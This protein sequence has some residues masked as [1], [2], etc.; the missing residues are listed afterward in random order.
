[1]STTVL[2]ETLEGV[3]TITL[4]RPDSLNAMNAELLAATAQAFEAA[5][6]DPAT[7]V[8]VLTGA[9]RAFCAGDDLRSHRQ[10]ESEAEAFGMVERIQRVT[11]SMVNGDRIVIGAI[12]GWAVGGGF[13]W[14][15]NCDLSIWA[16]DAKA[17]F[18]EL[19]WGMFPTGGVTALLP[20]LVGL[21]RAREMLFFGK[22]YTATELLECG[23]AWRVVPPE[24]LLD[25][26][27]RAAAELAARPARPLADLKR[28]LRRV[29]QP[30]MEAALD[31]ET[32][33]TAR[34]FMD[35][36]TLERIARFSQEDGK[37]G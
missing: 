27:L 30:E 4:N 14:A 21:T 37:G 8:I 3:C 34:A 22:R 10:P 36:Q 1:M 5:H 33:A 13:E 6:A 19:E 26:T 17:F 31:L 12:N 7:R 9:G 16:E 35:P 15:I 20:R 18:P 23:L 29:A 11:R 25:E 32:D 24:R 28:V 2:R